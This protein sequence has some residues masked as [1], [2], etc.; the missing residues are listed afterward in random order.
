[1]LIYHV[2]RGFGRSLGFDT[3][4][5]RGWVVGCACSVGSLGFDTPAPRVWMGSGWKFGV[6]Y[7]DFEGVW[8]SIPRL[9]VT[10]YG[11]VEVWGSIP[12][13]QEVEDEV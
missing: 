11:V 1:M 10:G 7:P 13:L 4:A 5:S 2:C 3:P 9:Q 8:G 6:R 12:R